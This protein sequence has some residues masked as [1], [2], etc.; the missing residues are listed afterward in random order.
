MSVETGAPPLRLLILEDDETIL[1]VL[2]EAFADE[3]F[4]ISRASSHQEALAVLC[5][6]QHDVVLFD[7]LLHGGTG[8]EFFEAMRASGCTLPAVMCSAFG[9]AE[10]AAAELGVPFVGKPFDLDTLVAA[11]REAVAAPAPAR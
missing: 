9:P 5:A 8:R 7:Y 3:G 10:A 11:I 2:C 6:Q 4:A 1:E